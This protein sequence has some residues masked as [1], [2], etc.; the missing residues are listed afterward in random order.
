MGVNTLA[1]GFIQQSLYV[2]KPDLRFEQYKMVEL[3]DQTLR[4]KGFLHHDTARYLAKEY[5]ESMGFEHI[6]IDIHGKFGAVPL[7]LSKPI[8]KWKGRFDVLTN[9]GTSEHVDDQY[10]CFKNMHDLVKKDGVYISLM[11]VSQ[12]EGNRE[13]N[14]KRLHCKYFY[15]PEFVANLCTSN[16]YL[17]YMMELLLTTGSVGYAY[18]KLAVLVMPTK[19]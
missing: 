11:P 1:L 12:W 14:I 13:K 15:K 9:F 16:G 7:D 3:G 4:L 18:K 2:Y 6:S 10:E 17:L 8:K 5:F 19:R